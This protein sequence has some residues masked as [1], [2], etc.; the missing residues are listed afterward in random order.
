[1]NKAQIIASLGEIIPPGTIRADVPFRE[2]TSFGVGGTIDIMVEPEDDLELSRL[3]KFIGTHGLPSLVIGGGSNLVGG[4][5][6][7]HGIAI[8]LDRGIFAAVK[9]GRRHFTCG[10]A[11]RLVELA[12][13][14]AKAGFGGLAELAGIP[15]TLGGALRMNAGARGVAIGSRVVQLCGCRTDGSIWTAEGAEINWGYRSSSI[16]DDVVVT[17]AIL[18]LP[19]VEP[20]AELARIS[21]EI[22]KRRECEPKGRSAGC[23]FK[24]PST[25]EPAGRLLDRAG[26]KGRRIGDAMIS[27]EHANYLINCGNATA[28]EL[29]ALASMARREVAK[30]FGIYL[31]PEVVFVNPADRE[32][33]MAAAVPPKVAVLKG[34]DSSEREVSL[35]S[36]AAVAQALRN[37]GYKVVEIDL[38]KCEITPEMRACDVIYPVLHGGFG[39]DGRLQKLLEE[40]D[41]PFVGSG[42][43][44]CDLVMDKIRTKRLLEKLGLP[45][46]RWAVVTP[47]KRSIP[48]FLRFPLILKAPREGSTIGIIKVDAP[49]EWDGALDKEFAYDRTLL[50]EEFI[51]G[52]E[53]TVPLLSGK[54]LPIIEIRSPHGF[55]DYDAKYVYKDGKTEY[56]C[57]PQKISEAA[58]QTMASQSEMFFAEFGCRDILRVDFMIDADDNLYILEG[59]AIPGC[60]ATSLVPKAAKVAGISFETMTSGLVRAALKR[61]K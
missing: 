4:D 58:Q 19:A 29:V 2:V 59:N 40:A 15:G 54:A 32:K 48:D 3:F 27:I 20:E 36:G 53:A 5:E 25:D 47:E 61:K 10:S 37:A 41:L 34:G 24:N 7:F 13:T 51:S 33:V 49:E 57:P 43:S 46:A 17:S 35:R 16:P 52:V 28:A 21:A 9:V 14:A 6:P 45:T 26:L 44:S 1:M 18:E 50:V 60:T 39:E 31:F 30:Q 8:R 12:R 23:F 11:V 56:F 55:Y 42:S 38:P 22:A